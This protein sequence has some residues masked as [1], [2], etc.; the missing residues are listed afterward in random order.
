MPTNLIANRSR[1]KRARA[2]PPRRSSEHRIIRIMIGDKSIR[3]RL[4]DTPTADL[5]WYALP[6]FAPAETWGESI[7]CETVVK[8]GRDRTA[9]LHAAAGEIYYC[10][11]D[12]RVYFAFGRTPISG[13]QEMRLPQPCNVWAVALDD[14]SVFRGT[15]PGEKISFERISDDT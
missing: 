6:L 5:M 3:A 8:S 9:K 1:P 13:P 7:H 11:A 4:L 15:T 12:E 10:A 14:L 2:E